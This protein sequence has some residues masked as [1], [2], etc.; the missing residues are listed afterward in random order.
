MFVLLWWSSSALIYAQDSDLESEVNS[1]FVEQ[2]K[3]KGVVFWLSAAS[4]GENL[5][6]LE[7]IN[8]E[9]DLDDIRE[10]LAEYAQ[11]NYIEINKNNY[12]K[13]DNHGFPLDSLS[14]GTEDESLFNSADVL[15]TEDI[16]AQ[17]YI[18]TQGHKYWVADLVVE[19][20]DLIPLEE[21]DLFN[22]ADTQPNSEEILQEYNDTYDTDMA[23]SIALADGIQ[24]DEDHFDKQTVLFNSAEPQETDLER[25][26]NEVLLN[27]KELIDTIQILQA[28]RFATYNRLAEVIDDWELMIDNEEEVLFNSAEVID[29]EQ[30]T[31]FFNSAELQESDIDEVVDNAI[32]DNLELLHMVKDLETEKELVLPEIMHNS[33]GTSLDEFPSYLPET[34]ASQ[35]IK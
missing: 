22:S 20:E 2:V 21:N 31:N 5:E 25:S 11:K 16:V 23:P 18:A 9:E 27:N 28:T 7:S 8:D 3:A 17:N 15:L 32:V 6:W 4:D 12:S 14:K 29:E 30:W 1:E 24:E 19:G 33:A 13:S 26:I 10:N 34:G 35:S